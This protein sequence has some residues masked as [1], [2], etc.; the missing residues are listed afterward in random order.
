MKVT[1]IVLNGIEL[2]LRLTA[3]GLAEYAESLGSGGNTLFAILDALDNIQNQGKLFGSALTYKGHNNSVTDG[4]ELIDML[5][6]AEYGPIEKKELIV[7]LAERSGV[8]GKVDA[9]KILAGIKSGNEK[10]YDTAVAI[11]SGTAENLVAAQHES[12]D[13][14]ENPT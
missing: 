8:I 13:T 2:K 6:D 14:E 7:Q 11:L 12:A 3:S 5:A 10:L 9:A 4:F 1:T